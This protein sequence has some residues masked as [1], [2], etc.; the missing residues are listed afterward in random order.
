MIRPGTSADA[1]G[2]ARVQV[3]TWQAAYAHALPPEQLQAFSMEEAVERHRRWPPTFVAEDGDRIVGF[4]S[5]G[6]SRD[7]G[8]DGELFAIYVHPEHWGTGAGRKLIEAGEE[9]L[10][11]LGHRDAI[12]WVLDDNPRARRFYEI[13]GWSADG[14]AR[15]ITVFGFEVA[16]V[17]YAKRL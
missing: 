10:R 2:V 9:E 16:E 4:V 1:E 17:R 11:S 13:A 14:A 3:E 5:V 7:P 12:L 6:S 8:T 15:E